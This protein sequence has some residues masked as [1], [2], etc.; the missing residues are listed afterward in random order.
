MNATRI[1]KFNGDINETLDELQKNKESATGSFAG[2]VVTQRTFK[3]RFWEKL[4]A[5]GYHKTNETEKEYL[6]NGLVKLLSVEGLSAPNQ[7]WVK[8]RIENSKTFKEKSEHI[9]TLTADDIQNIS[10]ELKLDENYIRSATPEELENLLTSEKLTNDNRVSILQSLATIYK[11]TNKT[12]KMIKCDEEILT[13]EN[14]DT[15][16]KR[17]KLQSLALAH[18]NQGNFIK[19]I[20][21]F[22]KILNLEGISDHTKQEAF[23]G[24]ASVY[25]EQ[26]NYEKAIECHEKNLSR[27]NLD[28]NSKYETMKKIALIHRKNQNFEKEIEYLEKILTVENLDYNKKKETLNTLSYRYNIENNSEKEFECYV[29]M[30]DLNPSDRDASSKLFDFC[31][32]KNHNPEK[33]IEFYEERLKIGNLSDYI[34]KIIS[35]NLS[36][37]YEKQN[38][39]KKIIELYEKK[40]NSETSSPYEKQDALEKMISI[41]EKNGDLEKAIECCRKILHLETSNNDVKQNALEK[42]ALI[43]KQQNNLEAS[44]QCYEKI[45]VLNA[46]EKFSD[47]LVDLY[48]E[49]ASTNTV[50]ESVYRIM[51]TQEIDLSVKITIIDKLAQKE[52]KKTWEIYTQLLASIID[53]DNPDNLKLSQE[54]I[55]LINQNPIDESVE[56]MNILLLPNNHKFWTGEAKLT[57]EQWTL[58]LNS[59][60]PT[61]IIEQLF[62]QKYATVGEGLIRDNFFNDKT[63]PEWNVLVPKKEAN[64]EPTKW[65]ILIENQ[66]PIDEEN[67]DELK[68]EGKDLINNAYQ[69]V[70]QEKKDRLLTTFFDQC[71]STAIAQKTEAGQQSIRKRVV[72][73]IDYLNKLQTEYLDPST[74]ESR[75]EVLQKQIQGAL[76]LITVGGEACADRAIVFLNKLEIY[77][78]LLENP[79]R[80]PNILVQM[81]KQEVIA[82][83]FIT[84]EDEEN[85][86]TYL[87]WSLTLNLI[88]GLGLPKE[89]AM[90]YENYAKKMPIEEAL[91][92]LSPAFTAENL[93]NFAAQNEIFRDAYLEDY[94]MDEEVGEYLDNARDTAGDFEE[95]QKAEQRYNR[96]KAERAERGEVETEENKKEEAELKNEVNRLRLIANEASQKFKDIEEKFYTTKAKKI[97][98]EAGFIQT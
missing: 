86:E 76:D 91:Q 48:E 64:K 58:V 14:I 46:K 9:D 59:P 81:F 19:A 57:I 85:I 7:R 60:N 80:I 39:L 56:L 10:L 5:W 18:K 72:L 29:R 12:E 26:N 38:E 36:S 73:C 1:F 74:D 24:I 84:T 75:K 33:A 96:A 61:K 40:L 82:A 17:L 88:L 63:T 43:Y 44:M 54:V 65:Q 34:S 22:E 83:C 30:L 66:E 35:N 15:D 53:E 93:I 50:K 23:S 27:E 37:V 49:I 13:F 45:L 11:K 78:K 67:W 3:D 6:L 94:Q 55:A 97:F 41:H 8:S 98:Q 70:E 4:S 31:E 79:D 21:Y 87:Y 77:L 32:K 62:F 47:K 51:K 25:E 69:D 2:R 16:T 71:M 20:E 92:K 42:M 68:T 95:A 52:P 90:L 28:P 89:E